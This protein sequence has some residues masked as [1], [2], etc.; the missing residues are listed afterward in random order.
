MTKTEIIQFLNANPA[1][2][3]ATADG[4]QPRV[5][6][7]LI[8]RADE[9]GILLHTGTTKD[10]C[11]QMLANPRVELCF[12]NMKDGVQV[13]VTGKAELVEDQKLKEEIVANRPFMKPWIEQRGYKFLAVFRVKDAAATVWTM[14]TNLELRVA[15]QLC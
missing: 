6:G 9:Q 13:R 2:H 15:I 8:Y 14:A 11:K 1:C 7:M 10:L 3:L 12:N 5:R 4:N